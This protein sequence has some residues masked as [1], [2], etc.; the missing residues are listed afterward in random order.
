M[1]R[2]FPVKVDVVV[3]PNPGLMTGPGTNTWIVSVD[4]ETAIIDPGPMIV[5]HVE[6]VRSA[7]GDSRPVAVLVTH[8]HPDHAPAARPLADDLGVPVVAHGAGGHVTP[9]RTVADGDT[10]SVGGSALTVV[11]TP[12]HTADSISFRLDA[13]LFVGDHVMGGSTVV[14]EDMAAYM[15]SLERLKGIGVDRLYP[16]HGPVIDAPDAVIDEYLEHRRARESEVAAA[17]S[18]G[19]ATV[20]DVVAIVYRD[21]DPRLHPVAEVSVAAHLRKLEGEGALRFDE[22]SGR[23]QAGTR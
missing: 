12:G 15:G 4:G 14:V 7:V 5:E 21:V 9:D 11:H 1:G 18:D 13:A 19:A 17:V 10:I 20:S 16:G 8:G 3:A 22:A 2:W 23:I 6:R